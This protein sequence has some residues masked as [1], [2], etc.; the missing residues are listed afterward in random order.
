MWIIAQLVAT[1]LSGLRTLSDRCSQRFFLAGTRGCRKIGHRHVEN[2]SATNHGSMSGMSPQVG[3]SHREAR[4]PGDKLGK[5]NGH[6]F[7][8]VDRHGPRPKPENQL[9]TIENQ[10]FNLCP[11]CKLKILIRGIRFFKEKIRKWQKQFFFEGRRPPKN[12]EFHK[13]PEKISGSIAQRMQLPLETLA[14]TS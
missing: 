6:D 2:R 11:Q 13:F 10:V 4:N 7:R 12:P 5:P 14:P 3:K 8:T 1:H 9:K